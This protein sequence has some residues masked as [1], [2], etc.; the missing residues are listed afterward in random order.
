ML[1]KFNLIIFLF[2]VS[3]LSSS[4]N[5]QFSYV[6]FIS[7][8]GAI[9]DEYPNTVKFNKTP[10]K[11][12][13]NIISSK[14]KN[15]DSRIYNLY[16]D[17]RDNST[18][19]TLSLV[20]AIDKERVY[21]YSYN[22]KCVNTY[23]LSTQTILYDPRDQ[24]ILSSYPNESSRP[25]VDSYSE[26]C[27]R[28]SKLDFIRFVSFYLGLTLDKNQVNS[29]TSMDEDKIAQTLFD[30]SIKINSIEKSSVL[31][32]VISYINNLNPYKIKYADE[33]VGINQ[34]NLSNDSLNFQNGETFD[35]KNLYFL[36]NNI[37]SEKKYKDWVGQQFVK[38]FSDIYSFP[39]IPYSEGD[40]LGRQ[41]KMKFADREELF[42]LELPDIDRGFNIS[43]NKPQKKVLLKENNGIEAYAYASYIDITFMTADGM[44]N[45]DGITHFTHSV[46]HGLV[47]KVVKGDTVNDWQY[48][49]NS[50]EELLYKY[51][52]NLRLQDT[53]YI[54]NYVSV[55]AKTFKKNSNY[56]KKELRL[57]YEN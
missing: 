56:L 1:R 12:L 28:S 38:W 11:I 54:K 5:V 34:I 45:S 3:T 15:N 42:N 55:D 51:I 18:D 22:N 8:T 57:N 39:L 21:S 9:E 20:V 30:K 33:N 4:E 25:Y 14:L 52:N 13:T 16:F 48:F 43:F 41:V 46:K 26:N 6:S 32:P 50:T 36:N 37:F 47:N 23:F 53:K 7:S 27:S 49:N 10:N 19:G 29:L 31:K 17:N 40:A 35:S 44:A 2:V 24:L